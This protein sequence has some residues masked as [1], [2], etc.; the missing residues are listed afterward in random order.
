MNRSRLLTSTLNTTVLRLIG[1]MVAL[2]SG[3]LISAQFGATAATDDY[4]TAL[5]LPGNLAN[6]VISVLTAVFAPIYLEHLHRDPDQDRPIRS[7]LAF[8]ATLGLAVAALI[9]L[10][11][12]PVSVT[13]RGL[14][15]PSEAER[16]ALFG[17]V[18]VGVGP[19]IGYTRLIGIACEARQHYSAPA[20]GVLINPVVFVGTLALTAQS[21]G[22][23]SLL[24][25]NVFGAVAEFALI[26][27]YSVRV[28][29]LPFGIAPRLHPAVREML[30][31]S[32]SPALAYL[33]IF[34]VPT[35]DRAVATTLDAGSLTAF[36]YGERIVVAVD[37]LIAGGALTVISNYWA[38][39]AAQKG[40]GAV[41]ESLPDGISLLG[42]GLIPMCVGGALLGQPVISVLFERGAFTAV[43]ASAQVFSILLVSLFMAHYI[44]LFVRLLLIVKNTAAQLILSLI[45][46]VLN[47][48]LNLAFAPVYGVAGIALSTLITRLVVVTGAVWYVRQA[49]PD[50][51][52]A[53]AMPRLA[54]TTLC[55]A[56]MMGV[57]I[58]LMGVLGPQLGRANGFLVQVLTLIGVIGAGAGAYILSAALTRHPDF[59]MLFSVAQKTRLGR[60]LG[61]FR[62]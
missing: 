2:G 59:I 47:T 18:L 48:V 43:T 62:R 24:V 34:F 15:G 45:T 32:V 33:A 36:H 10:I 13:A 49:L 53:R 5:I 61:V 9:S 50:V 38:N 3:I 58:G 51:K 52:I 7:S 31:R 1:Q 40:I 37:Y 35:V 16:A 19:L 20:I 46:V 12:V 44:V 21:L 8:V 54:H 56:I 30:A 4:Y 17:V 60:V 39:T 26:T 25:A 55:T 22:I 23:Y 42:F 27:G 57:V 14:S 41:A 29:R 6:L 11:A 28:L